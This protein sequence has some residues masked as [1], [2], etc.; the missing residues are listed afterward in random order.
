M[1]TSEARRDSLERLGWRALG[2]AALGAGALTVASTLGFL[3]E[4]HWLGPVGDFWRYVPM[5][6]AYEQG[7]ADCFW[8]LFQPHGG[9]RL[10][11]PRLLYLAE[12]RLFR[13]TNVFLVSCSVMLQAVT[14]LL[15]I[16]RTW[17]DG[18]ALPRPA[19][20]FLSGLILVLLFSATQIENFARAWNVHWFLAC[21]A[22]IWALLALVRTREA[23]SGGGGTGAA[24]AWLGLCIAAAAVS[25]YSMVSKKPSVTF[26]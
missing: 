24:V 22:M 3:W 4:S 21:S 16:R 11:F 25:T 6:R 15:L 1:P 7:D 9:H 20:W 13:G 17:R 23:L 18:G 12:Y 10:F 8:R 26:P 19:L 2:A 5:L 14:A